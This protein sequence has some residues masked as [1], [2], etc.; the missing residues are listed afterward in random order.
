MSHAKRKGR[1]AMASPVVLDADCKGQPDSNLV[2]ELLARSGGQQRYTRFVCGCFCKWIFGP[3]I[4]MA[5]H[6]G[7]VVFWLRDEA[8][9]AGIDATTTYVTTVPAET[10]VTDL[11]SFPLS[12]LSEDAELDELGNPLL[13]LWQRSVEQ[14]S[15]QPV[16]PEAKPESHPLGSGLGA[17][18]LDGSVG[19]QEENNK[20]DNHITPVVSDAKQVPPDGTHVSSVKYPLQEPTG[21]FSGLVKQPQRSLVPVLEPN[22]HSETRQNTTRKPHA[23]EILVRP[24]GRFYDSRRA[25][26]KFIMRIRARHAARVGRPL[27]QYVRRLMVDS[28]TPTKHSLAEYLLGWFT[29]GSFGF[30]V[31]YMVV[32][33]ACIFNPQRRGQHAHTSDAGPPFIGT[34]TLK[35]PPSWSI[36]KAHIYTLRSWV[37]DLVLWSTATEIPVERQAAIAALQITGSARELIR[38]IPPEQL[39]D[40]WVDPQTQQ[41]LTGLMV[42]VQHLARRYAPMEQE[43]STKAI[44]ELLNFIRMPGE[45]MDE[46]LV[47]FDILRTRAAVRGGLGINMQGLSWMLLRSLQMGPE[48]W[49][50]FLQFNGGQLP[51]NQD[52][53]NQLVERL[54]RFGHLQEGAMRH[55]TRQGA[56]GDP[57]NYYFPTFDNQ[58][59]PSN[60]YASGASQSNSHP[61]PSGRDCWSDG[62]L[63]MFTGQTGSGPPEQAYMSQEDGHTQCPHCHSYYDEE[64]SSGTDSDSGESDRDAAGLYQSVQVDGENRSDEAAIMNQ[65][66]QDYVMAKRRWRRMSGRPPRRYR[67]YNYK[68][69]RHV[70]HLQRSAFR[71]TF[72][73]FLPPNAFAAGKGHGKGGSKGS[74]WKK[75]PRGRDGKPLKCLRCGSE[76][77]LFKRCP[78]VVSNQHARSENRAFLAHFM[79]AIT[80]PPTVGTFN[81]EPFQSTAMFHAVASSGT[82]QHYHLSSGQ[83]A[84]A[85]VVSEPAS[86]AGSVAGTPWR[87]FKG[88]EIELGRLKSVS[89]PA[90]EVGS[91]GQLSQHS[92]ASPVN[93]NSPPTWEPGTTS[94]ASEYVE[95]PSSSSSNAIERLVSGAPDPAYPPPTTIAPK[96]PM[97]FKTPS[98]KKDDASR[99][100]VVDELSS[101]LNYPWWEVNTTAVDASES[102]YHLRTRLAGDRVGLLVDPGAHDNLVGESTMQRLGEQVGHTP[103]VNSLSKKLMV[104]GVGK[105]PNKPHKLGKYQSSC[106]RRKAKVLKEST[107]RL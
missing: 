107:V 99:K 75:N 38:E 36:E 65:V 82:A 103:S 57:G 101:F 92:Q 18:T 39:R 60:A 78:Q 12:E 3:M 6:A 14:V 41:H 19:I 59:F 93:P 98:R 61:G 42:L 86:A 44:S 47:R 33:L 28:E 76:E 95:Q 43:A 79:P 1:S 73:A 105:T 46:L 54:R 15:E 56:T 31:L 9:T 50:K 64:F 23:Y 94:A 16:P 90:S 30:A 80:S 21:H 17:S 22:A 25:F 88:F 10:T 74:Q 100:Q 66:Y 34:A 67:K 26:D 2:A 51:N 85:S 83:S 52:T 7:L 49:D 89:Q 58:G 104:E 81:V 40:G 55:G 96:V 8:V 63:Q 35:C 69:R 24:P 97:S 29:V 62:L 5:L 91:A 71:Q 106:V 11:D 32:C 27:L 68:Q 77:H 20:A 53:M 4:L 84:A 87:D 13:E 70:P 48:D 72:A 37:S 102:M 45:S